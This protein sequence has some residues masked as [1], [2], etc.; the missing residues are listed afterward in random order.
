MSGFLDRYQTDKS[1]EEEGV[2][3][4]FGGGVMVKVA[5]ITSAKSREVRRRL[6][7]P[8]ARKNRNEELTLDQLE[9]LMIEQLS[10]AVVK[11]WKGVTDE[12]G[13]ELPCTVENCRDILNKFPDFREDVATV[14][15]E[16][17]TFQQNR[18]QDE[19]GNS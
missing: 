14:S 17:A 16:K 5:R 13:K 12:K 4:D 6:E 8:L 2:W 15:M 10:Q 11:D 19:L 1:L 3:V 7:R 18:M 9:H